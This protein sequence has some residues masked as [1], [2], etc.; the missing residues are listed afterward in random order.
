MRSL[1]YVARS[2]RP[3]SSRNYRQSKPAIGSYHASTAS[4]QPSAVAGH[5]ITPLISTSMLPPHVPEQLSRVAPPSSTTPKSTFSQSSTKHTQSKLTAHSFYQQANVTQ[6]SP[7]VL[8]HSFAGPSNRNF[9]SNALPPSIASSQLIKRE[10]TVEPIVDRTRSQ[11]PKKYTQQKLTLNGLSKRGR[12]QRPS[13]AAGF[14]H[15]D[16]L[17]DHKPTR[18]LRSQAMDA[19]PAINFSSSLAADKNSLSNKDAWLH[20]MPGMPGK[21]ISSLTETKRSKSRGQPKILSRSS[22]N[23]SSS[24]APQIGH[25]EIMDSITGLPRQ[26][27]SKVASPTVPGVKQDQSSTE[28]LNKGDKPSKVSS[29]LTATPATDDYA[30]PL[31][32][33]KRTTTKERLKMPLDAEKPEA[34]RTLTVDQPR[35][36]YCLMYFMTDDALKKHIDGKHPNGPTAECNWNG[37]SCEKRIR[38]PQLLKDHI[39]YE[40][41]HAP[42]QRGMWAGLRIEGSALRR[43]ENCGHDFLFL[44]RHK[45]GCGK[46]YQCSICNLRSS[47]KEVLERHLETH[48]TVRE[49]F[50]CTQNGCRK[51]YTTKLGLQ[52]HIRGFHNG[53]RVSCSYC[54]K[55]Y[56][57][58]GISHHIKIHRRPLEERKYKCTQKKCSAAYLT[59][60]GLRSHILHTHLRIGIECD[61]DGCGA[62]FAGEAGWSLNY[63]LEHSRVEEAQRTRAKRN[64]KDLR[65]KAARKGQ[66][67]KGLM[68]NIHGLPK[69][70]CDRYG[71][72]SSSVRRTSQTL[73][74]AFGETRTPHCVQNQEGGLGSRRRHTG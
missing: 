51:S 55:K 59:P 45:Q 4:Q 74:S 30:K 67:S 14:S 64:A 24:D 34:A 2:N 9:T 58:S 46:Y 8:D 37:S 48:R 33:V 22:R 62:K 60:S 32:F 28:E 39:R 17:S 26:P 27:S 42:P 54:D 66:G 44:L 71:G 47:R 29:E 16:Q 57:V 19:A 20:L 56:T 12:S 69:K 63:R 36:R 15:V 11:S 7:S 73:L 38:D 68:Y 43:C 41:E 31:K 3:Q 10:S 5:S 6:R 1:S 23:I 61:I 50:H 70:G 72:I 52:F 49:R 35:C 21:S 13:S 65:S 25:S 18:S 53:E 40:H